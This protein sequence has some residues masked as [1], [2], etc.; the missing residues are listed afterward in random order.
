VLHLK[1]R[2]SQDVAELMGAWLADLYRSLSW[3]ANLVVPVP[4]SGRRMRHRGYNQASLVASALARNIGIAHHEDALHRTRD[5]RSQV[6]L[7]PGDRTRNVHQAFEGC[8]ELVGGNTVLVVDDLWTTGATLISCA[9]ALMSA[10]A[11][12]VLG[13]TVARARA[14]RG[15]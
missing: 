14:D 4:L 3:Q 10:G 8:R 9:E 11:T 13:L 2:P 12:S 5:T 1:Y 7:D 15:R 6:G